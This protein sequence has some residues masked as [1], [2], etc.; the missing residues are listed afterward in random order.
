[1]YMTKEWEVA[2]AGPSIVEE[3]KL[4]NARLLLEISEWSIF[5]HMAGLIDRASAVTVH[6]QMHGQM[7][8]LYARYRYGAHLCQ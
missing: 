5:L 6:G 2:G 4:L 3:L 8:G 1:M 7:H